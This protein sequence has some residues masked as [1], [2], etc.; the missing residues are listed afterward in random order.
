MEDE[1]EITFIPV[2]C[3]HITANLI[4]RFKD[5]LT[6]LEKETLHISL[7]LFQDE[8]AKLEKLAVDVEKD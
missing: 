8:Q 4:Q 5:D 3:E 7:A 6:A 2:V 1:N